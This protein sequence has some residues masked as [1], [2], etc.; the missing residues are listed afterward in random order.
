MTE[1]PTPESAPE[2]LAE[3]LPDLTARQIEFMD[4][5]RESPDGNWLCFVNVGF[6]MGDA[7][8]LF[9]KGLIDAKM[10]M[11]MPVA[12]IR[13]ALDVAPRESL[14]QRL[15]HAIA[16]ASNDDTSAI[17]SPERARHLQRIEAMR[18]AVAALRAPIHDAGDQP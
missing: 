18:D 16:T 1:S 6:T 17:G 5:L 15:E 2:S 10:Q 12:R 14:P 7:K 11:G 8:A 3:R 4:R 13:V 9:D